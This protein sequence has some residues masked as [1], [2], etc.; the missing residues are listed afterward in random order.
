MTGHFQSVINKFVGNEQLLLCL[1]NDTTMQNKLKDILSHSFLIRHNVKH[2]T[3]LLE[4]Q[5]KI[6]FPILLKGVF[7]N[8]WD[9]LK[10]SHRYFIRLS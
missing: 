6:T 4:V 8:F 9:I 3:R 1:Y 10:F 5:L 2:T 7:S